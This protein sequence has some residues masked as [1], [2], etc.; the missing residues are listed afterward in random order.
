MEQ[1][2]MMFKRMIPDWQSQSCLSLF[3]G[4]KSITSRY[5]RA[6][7]MKVGPSYKQSSINVNGKPVKVFCKHAFCGAPQSTTPPSTDPPNQDNTA[8]KNP[9]INTPAVIDNPPLNNTNSL[10]ETPDPSLDNT[11]SPSE[12]P[13]PSLDN[14]SSLSETPDPPLDNTSSLSETPDPPLEDTSSTS[15]GLTQ[16]E[17]D[18]TTSDLIEGVSNT[19]L[20]V[21]GM[22]VMAVGAMLSL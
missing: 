21:G 7:G 6:P 2:L 19:Y 15:D 12:T 11:S 9:S 22:A 18:N 13:D 3:G 17:S 4:P 1:R 20:A 10:S 14:T 5:V 8:M 16:S